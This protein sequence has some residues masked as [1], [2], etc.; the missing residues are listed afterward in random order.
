MYRIK[1]NTD[2]KCYVIVALFI[3][4]FFSLVFLLHV[5]S[6]VCFSLILV[7]RLICFSVPYFTFH[8]NNIHSVHTS[9]NQF[10]PQTYTHTAS[11]R[12]RESCRAQHNHPL[13]RHT[14]YLV[15]ILILLWWLILTLIHVNDFR[16]YTCFSLL[17]HV[18][19]VA[20]SDLRWNKKKPS[21]LLRINVLMFYTMLLL[22]SSPSLL[23]FFSLAVFLLVFVFSL[24]C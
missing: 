17:L 13:D 3:R 22:L 23:C 1:H 11:Q 20:H 9:R 16:V 12:Q 5:C 21:F 2:N 8:T 18:D 19:S 15:H 14:P 6:S 10:P 24:A 7:S 4:L